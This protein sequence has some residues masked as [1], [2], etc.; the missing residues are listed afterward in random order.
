V[1]SWESYLHELT[2]VHQVGALRFKRDDYFAPLGYGG[3]NGAK[4]RQIIWLVRDY[5]EANKGKQVGLLLAGSVKSPQLGRI[6]TVA[7]YMGIPAL[8]VIGSSPNTA[9][10]NNENVKIAVGMGAR[11]FKAP[12]PYNPVLQSTARKLKAEPQFRDYYLI[13]YGLSVDGSTERIESFYRFC[14]EQVQ[15]I[16]EDVETLFIPAGS[17]NTTIS[18]LYGISLYRPKSLKKIVLFGIGP[19]RVEWFEERLK[20]L[21]AHTGKP[22]ASLFAREYPHHPELALR[23]NQSSGAYQLMHYDLHSTGFASYDDEMPERVGDIDLHPTYEGKMWAYM[24]QYPQLF[25][26]HLQDGKTL[27]WIVGSAPKWSTM[28]KVLNG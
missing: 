17:C 14:A 26:K 27:F 21:E 3:I 4:V 28:A 7:R 13:E 22:L 2:P 6:S 19:P 18:L 8:L 20:L 12:A 5:L 15:S 25:Q 1:S 23:Y 10:K 9:V 11:F 16:P 24:R